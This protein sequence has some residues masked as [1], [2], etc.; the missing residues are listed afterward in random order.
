[1]RRRLHLVPFT[2]TIPSEKRNHALP[3]QLLEERDGILRWAIDGCLEWQRI[4]LNPPACVLSATE[5]YLESE[6]SL[7]R[8]IQ[9]ECQL[10]PNTRA[11]TDELYQS[12]KAWG[13]K[14]GE[15]IGS[16]RKFS[17]DLCKRGLKRARSNRE[18]IFIGIA[19][20][21]AQV[22]EDLL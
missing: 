22:Q 1:M 11:A 15:H 19:K 13:E 9:D 21:D 5:E 12:W 10:N 16:M 4:G 17:D 7:G 3:E 18:R 20:K 2:V 8:W 14:C 6:D